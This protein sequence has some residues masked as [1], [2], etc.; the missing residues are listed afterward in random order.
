MIIIMT[1]VIVL[2]RDGLVEKIYSSDKDLDIEFITLDLD[3]LDYLGSDEEKIT[4][5][6]IEEKTKD[7][8]QI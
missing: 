1:K 8:F 3:E 4:E 5:E 7:L 2:L 6:E